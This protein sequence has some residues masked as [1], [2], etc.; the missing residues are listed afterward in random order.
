MFY[1]LLLDPN[2]GLK[3][4]MLGFDLSTKTATIS[5]S[6]DVPTNFTLLSTTACATAA[7]L[8]RPAE[9]ANRYVFINSFHLTQNEILAALE[10]ETDAKWSVKK[11]TCMEESRLGRELMERGDWSGV[12]RAIMGASYSGGKFDFARG[13]ELDNELLGLRTRK[14]LEEI[15]GKIVRGEKVEDG[16]GYGFGWSQRNILFQLIFGICLTNPSRRLPIS[17]CSRLSS[18]HRSTLIFL[19]KTHPN[20]QYPLP[21]PLPYPPLPSGTLSPLLHSPAGTPPSPNLPPPK[22]PP[23]IPPPPLP[24]NPPPFSHPP[25]NPLPL[26]N[27]PPPPPLPPNPPPLPPNA[28]ATPPSTPGPKTAQ[29]TKSP[30]TNLASCSVFPGSSPN[31]PAITPSPTTLLSSSFGNRPSSPPITTLP[32]SFVR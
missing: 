17:N 25:P 8:E 3:D 22:L 26:A 15:V 28:G 32:N 10:N 13:R 30:I 1:L 19:P 18:C 31:R 14:T 21:L 23:L 2:R 7:I 27:S 9:T 11:T 24:L 6:G 29:S 20:P 4:G 5:D 12:G 16:T